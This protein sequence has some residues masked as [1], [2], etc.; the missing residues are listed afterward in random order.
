MN[1]SFDIGSKICDQDIVNMINNYMEKGWSFIAKTYIAKEKDINLG[2]NDKLLKL[3]GSLRI[4]YVDLIFNCKNKDK[5][6]EYFSF[7]SSELTSDYDITII[8]KN[9]P[10]VTWKIFKFFHDKYKKSLPYVFDTNIYCNGYLG[11]KDLKS[12][13]Y[14]QKVD[15]KISIIRPQTNEEYRICL[16][17]SLLKLLNKN[18]LKINLDKTI[19]L[20]KD[21]DNIFNKKDSNKKNWSYETKKYYYASQYCKEAFKYLYDKNNNDYKDVVKNLCISCYFS[22]E[23]YYTPSTTSVVVLELQAGKTLDLNKK[24]YILSAIENLGDFYNHTIDNKDSTLVKTSKYLY[25]VYYSLYKA[26]NKDSYKNKLDEFKNYI[27]P[28]RAKKIDTLSDNDK[29]II[30]NIGRKLEDVINEIEN[31]IKILF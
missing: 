12:T 30:K 5:S 23:S 6:C 13:N 8:G 25:R 11:N 17:F 4:Y 7:G 1:I 21:L 19:K 22:I 26:T 29:N 24:D 10:D 28:L 16:D 18:V 3:L 15:D 27:L 20:K 2:I 9:S 14:I 31:Q